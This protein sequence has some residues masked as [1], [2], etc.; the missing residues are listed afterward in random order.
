[1]LLRQ[2]GPSVMQGGFAHAQACLSV[3]TLAD[4]R[5]HSSGSYQAAQV[6]HSPAGLPEISIADVCSRPNGTTSA[7]ASAGHRS[8]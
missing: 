1:M 8:G 5:N 3:E 2:T 4:F 6:R 7:V